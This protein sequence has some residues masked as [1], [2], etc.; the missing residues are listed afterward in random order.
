MSASSA[1]ISRRTAGTR[2]AGSPRVRRRDAEDVGEPHRHFLRCLRVGHVDV[3]R[4]VGVEPGELDVADDAGDLDG[5]PGLAVVDPQAGPDGA[6]AGEVAPRERV[7]DQHDGHGV[8]RVVNGDVAAVEERNPERPEVARSDGAVVGERRLL[9]VLVRPAFD[10][11]RD[12]RSPLRERIERRGGNVGDARQAREPRGD[13]LGES[14]DRLRVGVA[15]LRQRELHAQEVVGLEAGVGRLEPLQ[16][17]E[18]QARPDEEHE[19]QTHF[20]GDEDGARPRAASAVGVSAAEAG[21]PAGESLTASLDRRG[22]AQP[23]AGDD[24]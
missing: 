19:R 10:Q 7:A 23:E 6:R 13:L 15:A 22:E 4:S 1:R 16:G 5:P 9:P 14:G 21:E 24:R 20:R 17:A 2:S 18:Q 8:G 3:R 12:V 11:E